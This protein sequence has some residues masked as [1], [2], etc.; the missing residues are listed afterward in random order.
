MEGDVNGE[1]GGDGMQFGR[2]C[3]SFD[4]RDSYITYCYVYIA[5]IIVY[6]MSFLII[7][8]ILVLPYIYVCMDSTCPPALCH[9]LLLHSLAENTS[10]LLQQ[11]D[12]TH[13]LIRLSVAYMFAW[14]S[15]NCVWE[16]R[17]C[18]GKQLIEIATIDDLVLRRLQSSSLSTEVH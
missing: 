2:R 1:E 9:S 5:L 6:S 14:M 12:M 16:E 18:S 17:G 4:L 15:N 3:F 13:K 7:C 8:T 10:G 11:S